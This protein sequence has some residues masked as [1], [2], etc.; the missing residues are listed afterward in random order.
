MSGDLYKYSGSL[1]LHRFARKS[2]FGKGID[3]TMGMTF[4]AR[5]SVREQKE[6]IADLINRYNPPAKSLEVGGVISGMLR[7]YLLPD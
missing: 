7:C 1:S 5:K 2:G 3:N 6:G 4:A